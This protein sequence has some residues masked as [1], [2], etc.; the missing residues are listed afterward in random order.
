MGPILFQILDIFKELQISFPKDVG[1]VSF[2][3]WNWSRYVQDGIYLMRQDMELMGN[4]AAQKLLNQIKYHTVI[5]DTT[6]LPVAMVNK[7]SI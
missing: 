4:V 7:P 1:L 6:I 5:S 2:D 3:D